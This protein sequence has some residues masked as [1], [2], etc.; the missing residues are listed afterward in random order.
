VKTGRWLRGDY[1]GR[2]R[3]VDE[4]DSTGMLLRSWV[5]GQDSTKPASRFNYS[6]SPEEIR[7]PLGLEAQVSKKGPCQVEYT[8]YFPSGEVS[9]ESFVDAETQRFTYAWHQPGVPASVLCGGKQS[10]IFGG[11]DEREWD[12]NGKLTYAINALSERGDTILFSDKGEKGKVLLLRNPG[13]GRLDGFGDDSEWV[14]RLH[15]AIAVR[16]DWHSNG[17]L[18]REIHLRHGKRH[19][20]WKEWTPDGTLVKDATYSRDLKVGDWVLHGHNGKL[21]EKGTYVNGIR[22]SR[23]SLHDTTGKTIWSNQ[24]RMGRCQTGKQNFLTTLLDDQQ[25]EKARNAK[26]GS[27]LEYYLQ[28]HPMGSALSVPVDSLVPYADLLLAIEASQLHGQV[29]HISQMDRDTSLFLV[30]AVIYSELKRDEINQ[31][32]TQLLEGSSVKLIKLNS[33]YHG[34]WRAV[35]SS[36]EV[37]CAAALYDTLKSNKLRYSELEMEGVSIFGRHNSYIGIERQGDMVILKSGWGWGDCES[38]CINRQYYYHRVYADMTA[39]L[40]R[41]EGGSAPYW[42]QD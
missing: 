37:I 22:N 8:Y 31:D 16:R 23:F 40:F 34:E 39:D 28:E 25:L 21:L 10:R 36:E 29:T 9:A 30:K 14:K 6:K 35:F 20:S 5:M 11:D 12:M 33:E 27:A 42:P 19:G 3:Y 32:L 26:L 7:M 2:T 13:V 38:G 1:G 18:A 41:E 15:N 17:Q 4:Y 24:Y